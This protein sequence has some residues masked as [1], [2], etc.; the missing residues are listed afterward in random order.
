M[1]KK[2]EKMLKTGV[3][4]IK[5]REAFIYVHTYPM[6]LVAEI[7]G[8]DED[9]LDYKKFNFCIDASLIEWVLTSSV[10]PTLTER[11][12]QVLQSRYKYEMTLE[13]TAKSI[14]NELHYGDAIKKERVRQIAVK[15]LRK[16]RHPSRLK[17]LT[18][19]ITAMTKPYPYNIANVLGLKACGPETDVLIF[20]EE[21]LDTI[22]Q[23]YP[24]MSYHSLRAFEKYFAGSGIAIC[25]LLDL[26]VKCEK[27][28]NIH[29]MFE[30]LR[31]QSFKAQ[32][33]NADTLHD[34]L[35]NY[36]NSK[37][38]NED[39]VSVDEMLIGELGLNVR[40]YNA[41][42]RSGFS[43][44]GSVKELLAGKKC[45]PCDIRNLGQKSYDNLVATMAIRG[46]FTDEP[47]P[48][49]G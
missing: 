30:W 25:Q 45:K 44:V 24:E 2:Y 20:V 37:E 23:K 19:F 31:K 11:E 6:N 33:V 34:A 28:H 47:I 48:Y 13:E 22:A 5:E 7:F 41:L 12:V 15:A 35:M 32:G 36:V 26:L 29:K 14:P 8:E 10:F 42:R 38:F 21:F 46:L 1:K 3:F 9:T 4:T 39:L 18:P 40:T 49:K 27:K 43:T 16:L 17:M